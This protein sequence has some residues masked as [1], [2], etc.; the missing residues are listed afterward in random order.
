M[1]GVPSSFC[2]LITGLGLPNAVQGMTAP[3][4][5]RNS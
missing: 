3:E 2:Q 1:A 4:L 5:F